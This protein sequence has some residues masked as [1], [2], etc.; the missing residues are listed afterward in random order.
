MTDQWSPPDRCTAVDRLGRR[1]TQPVGHSFGH[2][3]ED[4]PGVA[5]GTSAPTNW[6]RVVAVIG[7]ILLLALGVAAALR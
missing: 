6:L 3:P 7:L 5:P 1:C 4:V 2:V